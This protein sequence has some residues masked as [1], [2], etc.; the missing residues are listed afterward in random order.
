MVRGFSSVCKTGYEKASGSSSCTACQ[1][2]YY[3]DSIGD[4]SCTACPSGYET[5]S[6]GSTQSSDCG[7]CTLV[8]LSKKQ[9]VLISQHGLVWTLCSLF[10]PR[11]IGLRGKTVSL[12]NMQRFTIFCRVK[13]RSRTISVWHFVSTVYSWRIPT[14]HR[15]G[16]LPQ[17]P[18]RTNNHSNR[19][20]GLKFLRWVELCVEFHSFSPSTFSVLK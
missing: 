3:K 20:N 9:Q 8:K 16:N 18:D 6:T 11:E 1:A 7:E 4:Q 14:Q 17:M 12:D 10:C 13:L 15:T 19:A 2:N 5:A